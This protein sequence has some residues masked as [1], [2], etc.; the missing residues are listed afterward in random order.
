MQHIQQSLK[1][2]YNYLLP[3]TCILCK[4]ESEQELDLCRICMDAF[5]Q[6]LDGCY[7]CG[8][9]LIT[10]L[11]HILC[12]KCQDGNFAFDRLCALFRYQKPLTK[13]L[14]LIK[15][16]KSLKTA[17]VLGQLL[18]NEIQHN[19]NK[20][21]PLP[22]AIIPMPLHSKRLRKRGFN[23]SFELLRHVRKQ[24]DITILNDLCIRTRSTKAQAQLSAEARWYNVKNAFQ[25][26]GT[27]PY[28][29]V[30]I[31][32][33]VVTTGNTVQALSQVLRDAG[34]E[35]IDVWCICRA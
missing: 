32:D 12:E 28:K 4:H 33:D 8:R 6:F 13:L 31:M 15:F 3:K 5:P 7:G 1:K 27:I 26:C 11:E 35:G 19:W 17:N 18:I 23:Q 2:L 30:A 10:D 21:K 20:D 24:L 16:H 14:P 29:H 34:V 9:L 25:V 22:E